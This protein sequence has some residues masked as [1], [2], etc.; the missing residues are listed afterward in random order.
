[1]RRAGV[2]AGAVKLPPLRGR[3][4]RR[5]AP[6]PYLF[7]ETPG[8]GTGLSGEVLPESLVLQKGLLASP[9]K[10]IQA[11]Q[12]GVRLF[13]GWIFGEQPPEHPDASLIF[14]ALFVEHGQIQEQLEIQAA[15]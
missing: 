2:L 12:V 3:R 1:M 15:Q 5:K 9:A 6:S 13:P 4:S 8:L 11:H 7:V 14:L 10:G